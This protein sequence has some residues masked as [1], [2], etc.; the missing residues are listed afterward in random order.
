MQDLFEN[1]SSKNKEKLLKLLRS[2]TITYTKGV[3]ILSNVNRDNFIGIVTEGCLQIIINDYNGNNILLEEIGENGL[4]GNFMS[5]INNEE[6][7][8]ITKEKTKVTYIDYENITKPNIIKTDFYIIFIKNLLKI[9]GE[10]L[11]S[12]NERIEILT[13]RSI[14]DKLLEYF[15][16]LSQKKGSK[17]FTLPFTFIELA[18]YLSV[19]RC[20]MT[21][22]L[23][24]LKNEGFIKIVGKKVYLLY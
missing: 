7:S 18:N 4:F 21:R 2:S 23:K 10:Q 22:E 15:K 17:T 14:R 5:A 1:I 13:K 24:Y 6:C 12:K 8:C 20:A 9:L 16:L 19:D 3:N 11:T